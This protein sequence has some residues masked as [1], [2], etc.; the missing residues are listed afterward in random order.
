MSKKIIHVPGISEALAARKVPLSPVVAH[1]D[2]IFISGIPPLDPQ[3]GEIERSS[4]ERQ[5]E[6]VIENVRLCLEAAGSDLSKVLKVT[7]LITNSAYYEVVNVVYARY[8][9]ENCPART[10]CTVGSWPWPF[11]IEIECVAHI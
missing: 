10:F 8:F 11:D 5:T 9:K 7:I 3:T 1:N 6:V 4:I 2:L